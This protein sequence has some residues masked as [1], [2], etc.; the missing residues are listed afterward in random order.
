MSIEEMLA[1][2]KSN[3]KI[4]DDSKNLIISDVI[5]E[6]LSYCNLSELPAGLE[7]YIRKKVKSIIDYEAESGSAAVF[8]VK[9]IK[10]GDTSITYNTD[11]VSKETIYGL[12][13]SD[14]KVLQRYR[15]TRK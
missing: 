11:Q 1:M 14:K 4:L 7:P 13:A 15:R 10:E 12:S 2:V 3:L 6:A 8:D 5:R 9:S